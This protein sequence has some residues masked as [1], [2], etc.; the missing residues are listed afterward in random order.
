MY[1]A[2]NITILLRCQRFFLTFYHLFFK[3]VTF[4]CH[5]LYAPSKSPVDI[6]QECVHVVAVRGDVG[7]EAHGLMRLVHPLPEGE[8]VTC[9]QAAR[10]LSAG[11]TFSF[12]QR[13]DETHQAVRFC[14]NVTTDRDDVDALLRDIDRAF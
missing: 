2:Y 6:A 8:S 10:R 12:W 9:G 4:L 3:G 11:Y 1:H 14:T 7:A 13:V 5:L